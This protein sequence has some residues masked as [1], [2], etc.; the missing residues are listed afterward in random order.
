MK[1][2]RDG[3]SFLRRI[4]FIRTIFWCW[5]E[6]WECNLFSIFH[7]VVIAFCCTLHY[8]YF[9]KI[10]SFYTYHK[11]CT[12][13]YIDFSVFIM[14]IE[15]YLFFFKIIQLIHI[16][17]CIFESQTIELN[18]EKL[19]AKNISVFLTLIIQLRSRC[20][21]VVHSHRN[22]AVEWAL[23]WA[24]PW[25]GNDPPPPG[26]VRFQVFVP[27]SEI[28]P[29]ERFLGKDR[30]IMCSGDSDVLVGPIISG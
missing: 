12:D 24:L 22:I 2:E 10:I 27:V 14:I 15:H 18:P 7:K 3:F 19:F 13:T 20:F 26:I 5:I 23:L 29:A 21:L 28:K 11:G 1:N 9:S 8:A 17:F 6:I 25:A 4:L 16:S 30:R